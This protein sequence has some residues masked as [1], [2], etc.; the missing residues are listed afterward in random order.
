[1]R[2]LPHRWVGSCLKAFFQFH[3]THTQGT[4][5]HV[6]VSYDG[7]RART[8]RPPGPSVRRG[9]RTRRGCRF[10]VPV[11]AA[12]I[13]PRPDRRFHTRPSPHFMVASRPAAHH[14]SQPVLSHHHDLPPRDTTTRHA[15]SHRSPATATQTS[16]RRHGTTAWVL[17]GGVGANAGAHSP[18]LELRHQGAHGRTSVPN[19]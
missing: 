6:H 3:N 4:H 2:G 13:P 14:T 17:G 8:S 5:T 16:Q 7:A 18:Q 9:S 19:V 1:M 10:H 12:G 15:H 11:L